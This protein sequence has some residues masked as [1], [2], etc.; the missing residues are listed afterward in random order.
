MPPP[1]TTVPRGILRPD[2]ARSATRFRRVAPAPSLEPF[3]D[4]HWIVE[5]DQRG[6]QP[7]AQHVLPHPCV[8][9]VTEA[10]AT[11]VRGV[12]LGRGVTQLEGRGWVVGTRFAPA[13]FRAFADIPAHHLAGKVVDAATIFRHAG[14][15]LTAAAQAARTPAER[16]ARHEELLIAQ[17]PELDDG[18]ATARRI[19]AAMVA[20]APTSRVADIAAA[21][22]MSQRSL[23]RLFRDYVGVT[24]KAVLMQ[25]RLHLATERL[26]DDP[27]ID[28]N[29]LALDLGYADQSHFVN[30][31]R[32]VVGVPPARY[33]GASDSAAQG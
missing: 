27:L 13:A 20:A 15:E 4:W 1:S 32:A 17:D 19:V 18:M 25:H 12:K 33:A 14:A 24:P 30:D 23:Q 28:Q 6:R 7:F 11:I 5:W 3:V 26:T 2:A 10:S 31:F 8:N 9:L 29:D 16:I 22:A 21:H